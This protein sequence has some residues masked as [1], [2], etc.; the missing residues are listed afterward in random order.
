MLLVDPIEASSICKQT[1][2]YT[3][4]TEEF[5]KSGF[6]TPLFKCL[7]PEEAQYAFAEMYRGIRRMHLGARFMIARIFKAKYY[8]PTL[9]KEAQEY[10]TKFQKD[11]QFNPLHLVLPEKLHTLTALHGHLLHRNKH[12]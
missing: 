3:M 7:N 12:T 1:T 8:C 2:F 9:R 10:I 4:H 5:F 11:Q 6:T